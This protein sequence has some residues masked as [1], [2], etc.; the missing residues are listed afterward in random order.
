MAEQKPQTLAKHARFDPAFHFFLAPVF[1]LNFL[2][3]FHVAWEHFHSSPILSV[4][5]IVLSAALLM[6]TVLMRAYAL[7]VQDRVIR[8]EERLRLTALLG[9]S[10]SGVVHS[11]SVPQLVALRFVSD[12]EAGPLARRAATEGLTPKQIK[13]SIGVWRSDFHR[14]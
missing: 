3:S 5:W 7:K 6:L 9:P 4:W 1:V 10:D 13:E 12:A 14:V 8:L 11:L 2:L